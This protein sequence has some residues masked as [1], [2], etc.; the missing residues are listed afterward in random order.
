MLSLPACILYIGH[1]ISDP[2]SV[3]LVK[4]A[5]HHGFQIGSHTWAHQHLNELGK[6]QSKLLHV[7]DLCF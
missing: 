7:F 6:Y 4:Y 2:S 1:L 5:F 3:E